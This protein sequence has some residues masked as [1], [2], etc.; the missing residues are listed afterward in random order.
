MNSALYDYYRLPA[1]AVSCASMAM[2]AADQGFFRFGP[3]LTG[4]GQCISGVA[5]DFNGVALPDAARDVSQC[6]SELRLPFDFDRIVE[7]LRRERYT[8]CIQGDSQRIVNHKLIRSAYYFVRELLPVQVRRHLQRMYLKDWES[9]PFPNWPVDFT[10]DLLHEELLRRSM[11]ATGRQ[12]I[13]FVWFWPEGAESCLIMTHDVETERGRDFTSS[14]MDLDDSYGIKA[15]FEVIPEKRYEVPHDYVQ[16]IRSRGF[17]FNIHDLNHDSLLFQERGEFLRRAKKINA[18]VQ[19]F[20]ARGFR[21]GAMYRNQ[22]WF[23]AFDFSYDMS[24]PNVAHLEPQRGGCCTVMPHYIGNILELPLTAAQDYSLVHILKEDTIDLWKWQINLIRRRNGLISF[25]AH[26]D[27]VRERRVRKVY[28]ALLDYLRGL[29]TREDIWSALPRDVDHW[30]RVRSQMCVVKSGDD[31]KIE[32]PEAN[33]ARLAYTVLDEAGR[34]AYE[35]ASPLV[36]IDSVP[37]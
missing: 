20:G 11:E 6:G 1:G 30:W 29:V 23:D 2:N 35:L 21:T 16:Q 32:G 17:E 34:L 10:V 22:D 7:N 36:P 4:Y 26:P 37:S 13:P 25:I 19:K 24:V 31:W 14:L 12:R 5:S 15:S 18:Y 28:E 9:L 27:Y 3:R 8:Q 33:R